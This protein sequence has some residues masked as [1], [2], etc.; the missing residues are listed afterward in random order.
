MSRLVWTDAQHTA[1]RDSKKQTT[2]D[3][4]KVAKPPSANAAPS[5]AGGPTTA[6]LTPGAGSR[7]VKRERPVESCESGAGGPAAAGLRGCAPVGE[8]KGLDDAETMWGPSGGTNRETQGRRRPVFMAGRE[9]SAALEQSPYTREFVSEWKSQLKDEEPSSGGGGGSSNAGAHQTG[10]DESI[11][12]PYLAPAC[13]RD[14]FRGCVFFL[15]SCG[16]DA[17]ASVYLL[18]RLLRYMGGT[19]SLGVSNRV[20]YVVATQLSSAKETKVRTRLEKGGPLAAAAPI[21]V[22]PHFILE[23]AKQGKRLPTGPFETQVTSAGNVAG[24][25]KASGAVANMPPPKGTAARPTS[26]PSAVPKEVIELD[27]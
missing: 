21:I 16:A 18:E 8:G 23:C 2:L 24:V 17:L 19:T 6:V 15:N 12:A 9:R 4:S 3:F 27:D 11:L 22:H 1:A 7:A 20:T 25:A 10:F 5:G 26:R 13:S 14:V